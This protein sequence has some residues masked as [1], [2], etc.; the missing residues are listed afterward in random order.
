MIMDLEG[1][2]GEFDLIDHILRNGKDGLGGGGTGEDGSGVV[3]GTGDDAAVMELGS[4]RYILAT[5]DMMVEGDHF[6]LDWYSPHQVG[7]KAVE[8]NVS[9]IV[10]M[11]GWPTY[12]LVSVCLKPDMDP[13]VLKGV[14]RGL[15]DGCDTH[16]VALVGGDT[17]H[18]PI[19]VINV[20]LLG[21]VEKNRL[22]LRKGARPG[23]L[24]FVSGPTGGSA[25]GLDILR[26]GKDGP[27]ED[28]LNPRCNPDAG[29]EA[30]RFVRAMIDVSDGI[31][32][33]VRHL[34]NQAK[35]GARVYKDRIP[36]DNS[37]VL[38]GG[39]LGKDPAR[40]ALSGG[41]DYELVA[42]VSPDDRE[43]AV[44]LGWVEIG[45]FTNKAGE[46]FLVDDEGETPLPGGY[47]HFKN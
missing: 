9:D 2:G 47:D 29:R 40:Y 45:Q 28:H 42:A 31:A 19:T 38:A 11:G 39:V 41:E 14:Y 13:D 8:S 20:A 21:E 3:V 37:A 24:I 33:E 10:A 7:R 46:Y 5:T 18:G 27:V 32:S 25:A 17:T 15:Y 16:G 4:D 44:D 30:S 36:L 1:V 34:A 23:D 6:N 12:M 35:L 43:R 26:S 22:C